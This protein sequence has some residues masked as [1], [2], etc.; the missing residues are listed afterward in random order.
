MDT[1]HANLVSESGYW[2]LFPGGKSVEQLFVNEF[3]W[4][5]VISGRLTFTFQKDLFSLKVPKSSQGVKNN[6]FSKEEK[7]V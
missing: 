5:V 1:V 4:K 2:T 3:Y 6:W 7:P